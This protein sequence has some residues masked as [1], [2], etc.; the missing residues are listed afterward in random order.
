MDVQERAVRRMPGRPGD[1]K[2][3]CES[4][5]IEFQVLLTVSTKTSSERSL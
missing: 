5:K 2:L 1:Q 3:T 4:V